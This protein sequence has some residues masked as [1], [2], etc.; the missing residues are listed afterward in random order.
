MDISSTGTAELFS[1]S[2]NQS[3]H[4]DGFSYATNSQPRRFPFTHNTHLAIDALNICRFHSRVTLHM[5][6]QLISAL[7][8]LQ[9]K[10][11]ATFLSWLEVESG[12][13][14]EA[15][16]TSTCKC[17]KTQDELQMAPTDG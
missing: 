2:P 3:V 15:V 9:R 7:V 5:P 17:K 1:I 6:D 16:W 11:M 8:D 12:P 10:K 4:N 13:K 14:H